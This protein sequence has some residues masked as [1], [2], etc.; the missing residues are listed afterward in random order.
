M[1]WVDDI[2]NTILNKYPN[3]TEYVCACGISTTGIAHIGNFRELIITSLVSNELINRQKKVRLILS[4]DDF[5]R[6]KKVPYGVG[7]SFEKYV[8]M[9]NYSVPSPSS[10]ALS[11]AEFYENILINELEKLGIKMEY[12]RQS[13]NYL[14]GK[15]NNY[16]RESLDKRSNI[17]DIISSYKGQ[18]QDDEDRKNFYPVKIYCSSCNKDTTHIEKYENGIIT[19]DCKCGYREETSLNNLKIKLNFNVDWPMRWKYENVSFE[20]CGKGH[21]QR[22]SALPISKEINEKVLLGNNPVVVPYEFFYL[23]NNGERMNKNS[24]NLITIS[25]LLEIMPKE[26]VL[27]MYLIRNPKKEIFFSID[28]DIISYYQKFEELLSSNDEESKRIKAFLGIDYQYTIKFSDLVKYLPLVNFD[29]EKLNKYIQLENANK[30]DLRKI[31]YAIKWLKKYQKGNYISI[32]DK[33]NRIFLDSLSLELKSIIYEFKKIIKKDDY[34][35][36]LDMFLQKLRDSNQIRDFYYVFYKLVFNTNKGMPIKRVLENFPKDKIIDLLESEKK[37]LS[38]ETNILHLSDLHFD[39]NDPCD[40]LFT[41]WEKMVAILKKKIPSIKYFVLSGDIIC[42]YNMHENYELAYK[43]LS[44]L[45]DELKIDR[46]K[47][48]ICT[49][50]HEMLALN[51]IDLNTFWK[52]SYSKDIYPIISEY[53]DFLK[54]ITGIELQSIEDLYYLK[55]FDECDFMVINSLFAFTKDKKDLFFQNEEVI[56]KI[57]DHYQKND[58]Q[59]FL[60]T[61]AGIKYNPSLYKTGLEDIFKTVLCGHKHVDI[62]IDTIDKNS[63]IELVSGNTDGFVDNNNMYMLYNVKDKINV[64]KLR[65][66]NSWFIE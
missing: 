60:V 38:K 52:K 40:S 49:G 54:K 13:E 26:M 28:G 48:M 9:P 45:V 58:K 41:K 35:E 66:N 18:K 15:Y 47:I 44:Y 37:A 12:V 51:D 43:Y 50:N 7:R 64:K 3:E 8:G 11:Y 25:D 16:I 42:F 59:R 6:L 31:E 14:A 23:K 46:D 36:D 56:K 22:N 27:W 63:R 30:F 2:V 65:Y 53:S 24:G 29:I 19:Y 57:I 32:L 62:N 4:F 33:P 17:Y 20:P 61:H 1:K 34:Q 5:D 10:S 21:A 39:I 55:K